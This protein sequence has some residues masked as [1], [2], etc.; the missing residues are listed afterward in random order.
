MAC[1]FPIMRLSSRLF[2][3]VAISILF[4]ACRSSVGSHTYPKVA[5]DSDVSDKQRQAILHLDIR[6]HNRV[7]SC[8]KSL[9]IPFSAGRDL[10]EF[11][12]ERLVAIT[13]NGFII[14]FTVAKGQPEWK[15]SD[16]LEVVYT[17]KPG[18]TVQRV[19]VLFPFGKKKGVTV[20]GWRV[21]GEFR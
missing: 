19:K 1:E 7:M 4:V 6:G 20:S 14:L 3:P 8:L 10:D 16:D 5:I 18:Q 12:A 17:D 9:A 15:P 11:D 13:H 2:V 21:T